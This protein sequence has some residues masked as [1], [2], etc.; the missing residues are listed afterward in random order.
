MKTVNCNTAASCARIYARAAEIAISKTKRSR[1]ASPVADNARVC[2]R[3]YANAAS[4]A[5]QRAAE[6]AE[7]VDEIVSPAPERH[8]LIQSGFRGFLTYGD[9]EGTGI[10]AAI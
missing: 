4:G 9:Y 5:N 10:A 1:L 7:Y 3:I 2:A 6:I 8:S